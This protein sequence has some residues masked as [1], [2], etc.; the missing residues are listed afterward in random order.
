MQTIMSF[1]GAFHQ[2]LRKRQEVRVMESCVPEA[3]FHI[4]TFL[5]FVL[6]GVACNLQFN[7]EELYYQCKPSLQ[8]I[9]CYLVV[10]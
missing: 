5:M 9:T 4:G 6:V 10:E 3:F 7:E 1:Y 2:I 8:E